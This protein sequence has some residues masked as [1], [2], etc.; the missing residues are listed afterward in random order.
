MYRAAKII[1]SQPGLAG[2]FASGSGVASQE[3]TN[4]S[5]GLAKAFREEQLAI[6]AVIRLGGNQEDRA[7]ALL[8][9]YTRDLPASVEGY[10]KDDSADACAARLAT[11]IAVQEPLPPCVSVAPFDAQD[12]YRFDTQTGTICYDHA[13]CLGCKSKACIA[14]CE[15]EILKLESGRPVLA[16]TRE[17]AR[18]GGC[19]ECLACELECAFE[20]NGGASISLPIE[21]LPAYRSTITGPLEARV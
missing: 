9:K 5:R 16:I 20:G 3:Q 14:V 18:K 2:Y 12:P 10:K 6:P 21:G 19:T 17:E 4:G 11:L 15:P 7:V 1:L 8:H 13:L